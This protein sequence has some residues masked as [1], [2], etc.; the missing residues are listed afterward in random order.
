MPSQLTPTAKH[1]QEYEKS[2]FLQKENH[3]RYKEVITFQLFR[4]YTW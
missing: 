3:A 1:T 2:Q 4:S